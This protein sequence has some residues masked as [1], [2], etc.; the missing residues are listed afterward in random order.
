M[1]QD[2]NRFQN[3]SLANNT[4]ENNDI[5]TVIEKTD[6]I[7]NRI[8]AMDK[9]IDNIKETTQLII[10]YLQNGKEIIVKN[11]ELPKVDEDISIIPEAEP[12]KE[13]VL[14]I[15]LKENNTN[16]IELPKVEESNNGIT[17]ID[18]LLKSVSTE[19]VQTE[20]INNVIDFPKK[21]EPVLAEQAPV[22][23][24]QTEPMNNIIN[25][26][27][28]EEPVLTEPVNN[29]E[30]FPKVEPVQV[31][32]A[33]VAPVSSEPIN[34]VVSLPKVEEK[35]IYTDQVIAGPK[36][37]SLSVTEQQQQNLLRK[38]NSKELT[39]DITGGS[40]KGDSLGQAS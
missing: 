4:M 21:E 7:Q 8:D 17:S 13:Y 27:K 37:R 20:P 3:P 1:N 23:S 32:Q 25:F 18:D 2:I 29:V 11:E 26:P 30:N 38:N 31:E 24:V 9:K 12:E 10:D 35:D 5:K 16:D 36:H 19:P 6:N 34:N 39:L 33:P 14:D 28:K 15:P 22:A 40:Y